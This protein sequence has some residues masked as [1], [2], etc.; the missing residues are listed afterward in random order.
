MLIA[1]PQSPDSPTSHKQKIQLLKLT[2]QRSNGQRQED[3]AD[4]GRAPPVSVSDGFPPAF[5]PATSCASLR[6]CG[7]SAQQQQQ[8][9]RL[10]RRR[11]RASPSRRGVAEL[12]LGGS[13][14][15]V[16]ATSPSSKV[17]AQA[18]LHSCCV[19][20][21][22]LVIGGP[23]GWPRDHGRVRTLPEDGARWPH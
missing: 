13:G 15:G 21:Q 20:A 5:Y 9:P 2:Q 16:I 12:S 6:R 10:A 19:F 18:S 23:P 3:S 11:R 1:T 8:S 22:S 14:G 7:R 17:D 4:A